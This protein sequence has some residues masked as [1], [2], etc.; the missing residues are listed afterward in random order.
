MH[1]LGLSLLKASNYLSHDET[2]KM[3]IENEIWKAGQ[4]YSEEWVNFVTDLLDKETDA[5]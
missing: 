1:D 5:L 4:V 2:E 3:N